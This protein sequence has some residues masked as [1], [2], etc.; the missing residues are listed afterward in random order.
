MD[1]GMLAA[2]QITPEG[3]D[4]LILPGTFL[5]ILTGALIWH[6]YFRK[7]R[8]HRRKH[9]HHHGYRLTNVTIAQKGGLPPVRQAEK[10][11]DAPGSTF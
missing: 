11:P 6:F 10:S 2:G 3:M 4:F 9:H 7:I 8:R 1:A 5:L